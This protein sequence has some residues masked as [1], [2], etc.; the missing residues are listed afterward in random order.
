MSLSIG[1]NSDHRYLNQCGMIGGRPFCNQ[2]LQIAQA[3]ANGT[4]RHIGLGFHPAYHHTPT[5]SS[6]HL[7]ETT[8]YQC[9][10]MLAR[11][12][13]S[14]IV[15]NTLIV[16]VNRDGRS[17]K[18]PKPRETSQDDR[19]ALLCT[20]RMITA[21]FQLGPQPIGTL[22][23]NVLELSCVQD[24]RCQ[25]S[26]HPRRICPETNVIPLDIPSHFDGPG[27]RC[28]NSNH[29]RQL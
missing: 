22:P 7:P 10:L 13:R 18:F 20:N 1:P 17:S 3:M 26:V 8:H 5:L 11:G 15:A 23:P 16:D 12:P 29:Q 14:E 6:R 19:Q 9:D 2:G 21:L 4:I 24:H 25:P 28:K 27:L